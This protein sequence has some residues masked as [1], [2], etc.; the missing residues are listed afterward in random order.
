MFN[1]PNYTL[2]SHF[3]REKKKSGGV[4]VFVKSTMDIETINLTSIEN[5]SI[6]STCELAAVKLVLGKTVI[7]IVGLYRS[8]S[9]NNFQ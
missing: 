4:A 2:I 6:E 1:I 5:M 9:C 7:K 8:P 3:C